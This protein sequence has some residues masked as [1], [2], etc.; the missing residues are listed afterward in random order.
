MN[1]LSNASQIVDARDI[2]III[3]N[4][5]RVSSLALLI[6]AL[7][8]RGYQNIY[9]IDNDSTYPPLLEY[10]K[11]CPYKIFYLGYNAGYA[12]LWHSGLIKQF[13]HDY[14]A[15]TDSDITPAT[16]CPADFLQ[17][18]LDRLRSERNLYK[19]GLSLRI[20]DLPDCF[21]LKA[22]V[23]A[24]E[25]QFYNKPVDPFFFEAVVDT[26]FALYKPGMVHG[27]NSYLRTYRSARPYEL[28]HLP[29]YVDSKHLDAEEAYYRAHAET[30]THWT[31]IQAG[32]ARHK[33][34]V[35]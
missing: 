17:F 12:S 35:K 4:R 21:E 26:T 29:W 25:R 5:N 24:W 33:T 3:N 6:S 22:Q 18:F 9:I 20:D 19:I 34:A 28:L 27:A 1:R 30:L 13:H 14:F 15:Y 2:P 16:E 23:I 11:S 32:R 31:S 10:Y 7:E 8:T